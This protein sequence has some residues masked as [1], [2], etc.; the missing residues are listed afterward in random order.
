MATN[1]Y[2]FLLSSIAGLSTLIGFLFIFIKKDRDSIISKALGFASGVMFT[3]SIIDLIPNSFLLVIKDYNFIYA[4]FLIIMAFFIGIII[5]SIINKKVEKTSKNGLKLYKL[6]IITMV[7]IMMH[8]IPEGIATFITT[9]NNT[10][11]GIIL[12]IAIALHN[13]PEG[14]S[15]SIPIY[16]STNNKLKAFLYTL[17]SGMSEPLGAIISYLFLSRFV[18]DTILGII[19]SIIAGMMINISINELY[20]EAADYNKKNTGLYFII[21]AFIMILNHLLFG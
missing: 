3:I 17:I 21:G 4:L 14:I 2:A 15:I 18:N 9:T 12:T 7:V 19:Y 8:N 10:K 20:K 5:S 16:Y 11:L 13:I 1:I 6:G